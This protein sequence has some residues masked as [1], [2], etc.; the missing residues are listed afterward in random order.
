M[1]TLEGG[2]DSA[3]DVG[4]V[5]GPALSTTTTVGVGDGTVGDGGAVASVGADDGMSVIGADE[6]TSVG[7]DVGKNVV[8]AS[9]GVDVGEE[10]V[11]PLVGVELGT[12]CSLNDYRYAR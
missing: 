5:L 11:G 1:G 9:L 4:L 3:V 10:L 7:A 12:V 2:N 6:G 8:G